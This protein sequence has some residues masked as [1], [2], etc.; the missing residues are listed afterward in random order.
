MEQQFESLK[1]V[2]RPYDSSQL[3]ALNSLVEAIY[4]GTPQQ[5]VVANRILSEIKDHPQA[6]SRCEEILLSGQTSLNTKFYSLSIYD[7]VS[8]TRWMEL[9]REKIL[10]TVLELIKVVAVRGSHDEKPLLRKLDKVFVNAVKNEWL[11]GTEMWKS[12]IPQLASL[13]G[14]DQN[15]WENTMNILNMLSEDI[16][17]FGTST[18]TA[19]KIAMLKNTLSEQF[20]HVQ[21]LCEVVLTQYVQS[22]PNTVKISLV[23]AA[24]STMSHY[25][26]WIPPPVSYTHL[27]LPTKRIV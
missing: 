17:D 1:D 9:P 24:L 14:S 15:L 19:K 26:K 4:T 7:S 23:N 11:N 16:F 2:S 12:V 5:R 13:S 10:N 21:Q 22:P 25:L 20:P 8:S 6:W 18:M 27:T 3:L